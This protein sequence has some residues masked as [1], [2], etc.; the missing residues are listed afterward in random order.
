MGASGQVA[1]RAAGSSSLSGRAISRNSRID[2]VESPLRRVIEAIHG[3]LDWPISPEV[4]EVD[5]ELGLSLMPESLD[6]LER[7]V[8]FELMPILQK[9]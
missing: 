9:G 7:Q 1:A 5:G 8:R 2:D 6:V 3:E 4:K